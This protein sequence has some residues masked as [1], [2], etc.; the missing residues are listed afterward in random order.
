MRNCLY[1]QE[2]F[3]LLLNDITLLIYCWSIYFADVILKESPER[4]KRS[5][6]FYWDLIAQNKDWKI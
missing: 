2:M 1:E 5:S 6:V 4:R 3:E